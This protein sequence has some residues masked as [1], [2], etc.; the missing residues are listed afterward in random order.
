MIFLPILERELRVRA[1]RRA[2]HWAR[3][4]VGG[5]GILIGLPP[6]LWSS[7]STATIGRGS[8]DGLVGGAFLLCCAAC[9]LT[10]DSISSERREGTLGLLLLTRVRGL[11][12][13]LGKFASSGLASML[14]LV[15]F[16]PVLMLP[17][18]AGGVTGGEAAR[19]GLVLCDT[20]LFSLSAGLWASVGGYER[21]RTARTAILAVA[22][23]VLAPVLLG[24]AFGRDLMLVSPIGAIFQASDRAYRSSASRYWISLAL[25][26]VVTGALLFLAMA[27]L[28]GRPWRRRKNERLSLFGTKLELATA[29]SPASVAAA[30]VSV[31]AEVTGSG[32]TKCNYCG[33]QNDREAIFCL[34]CG[35][36]LR[37]RALRDRIPSRPELPSTAPTPLHWLLRRQRDLRAM[38]WFAAALGC[39]HYGF[40][41]FAGGLLGVGSGAFF[42]ASSVFGLA[43]TAVSGA[44]FAWVASRFFIEAR[45][46]GELELLATTPVGAE[47]II[48]TQWRVLK[49]WLTGPVLLML[50]PVVLQ[51]LLIMGISRYRLQYSFFT[52]SF[53]LSALNIVLHTGALCWVGMW[54][55]LR[56][57]TQGRA[58]LWTVLM[59][60]GPPYFV[61]LGWSLLF[62]RGGFVLGA[63]ALW[64][65]AWFRPS[66]V[67][68][69]Y[70]LWL[71]SAARRQL[72]KETG[73][74]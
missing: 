14:A 26:Q 20:L 50:A 43:I 40:Y 21:F 73:W 28:R 52:A 17:L 60:E 10:A 7:A 53:G 41:G 4:A 15:A 34:G 37:P 22:G 16:L 74:A 65:F 5:I 29:D 51:A 27:R 72:R 67:S 24:W 23:L 31:A 19:K 1:R 12:V 48:P 69:L 62:G 9:L 13:L 44:I 11:E 45:R 38:L 68:L 18:L 63:F 47:A 56:A 64:I 36:E 6:L 55:G 8:F 3:F 71:I 30:P 57:E 33:R 32:T 61:G 39:L 70:S 42:A 59:V 58:I 54:C 49:G 35:T 66:L 25:V 46:T 2:D